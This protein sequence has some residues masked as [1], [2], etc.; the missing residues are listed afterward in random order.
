MLP[1]VA[2]YVDVR[3]A[4]T[5]PPMDTLVKLRAPPREPIRYVTPRDWDRAM[6]PDTW[7]RGGGS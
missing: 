6:D 4:P 7:R 2:P 1:P 3:E 5:P